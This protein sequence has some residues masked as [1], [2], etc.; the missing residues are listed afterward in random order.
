MSKDLR[1]FLNALRA[2]CPDEIIEV[3][4]RTSC[5]LSI[6]SVLW[7]LEK[8]GTYPLVSFKNPTNVKGDP[9]DFSLVTNVFASRRRCA[10]VLNS[11]P[12]KVG[13]DY[14]RLEGEIKKPSIVS[15]D[16]APVKEV[17]ETGKEVNLQE[18]PIVTHHEKD[19]GPYITAGV[20]IVK[21]EEY[22]YNAATLRMGYKGPRKLGLMLLPGRHTEAYFSSY[23]RKNKNMPLVI[24]IGHHP[25]FYLGAQTIQPID[26]D[27]YKIIGG[28][29]REPLELVP[30]ETW[31]GDFLIPANAEIVIEGEVLAKVRGPEGPFGEFA[32]YYG[33]KTEDGKVIRITAINM[34]E[35]AIYHDIFPGHRDHFILGGIPL[36]GRIYSSVKSVVH[37]VKNVYLPPSASCR[38]HCYIQ[39]VK[40]HEGEGKNAII[41]ALGTYD[42]IKHVVVVDEDVN[43]FDENDVLWAIATRSQ[44]DKD[45]VSITKSYGVSIDP[46]SDGGV[47]ARGGID[48]TKPLSGFPESLRPSQKLNTRDEFT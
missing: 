43:I 45:L 15:T 34:R 32:R 11:T 24:V 3:E 8:K 31:G 20:C 4:T 21:H 22:G 29:M 30:S 10:H 36:E 26:I 47:S 40:K 9:S 27:E 28:V 23:E 44:W 39:I 6:P 25:A 13:L 14:F 2:K 33:P 19:S 38:F 1:K 18:F 12:E 35:D 42:V 37:G 48:A 41:A 46:S 17:I 5:N 7:N 16:K